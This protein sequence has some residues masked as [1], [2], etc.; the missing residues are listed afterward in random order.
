MKK[1]LI[2]TE[3]Q[4]DTII[5]KDIDLENNSLDLIDDDCTI[6]L[7][8]NN[9]GFKFDLVYINGFS[10]DS[11]ECKRIHSEI[12]SNDCSVT[13]HNRIT[14]EKF[15]LAKQDIHLTKTNKLYIWKNIFNKKVFPYFPNIVK[16]ESFI[17][18]ANIKTALEI[19]FKNN[20]VPSG[21]TYVA[22]VVGVAPIPLDKRGWSIMN[23]F[24]T[25]ASVHD[26]IKLFLARDVKNNTFIYDED[27]IEG[28]VIKWLVELFKDVKSDDMKQLLDIQLTSIVD[29]FKQ[30]K[31]DAEKIRNKYHPGSEI[32][33][34]GFGTI[35]DIIDSID[36]TIDDVTYQIKPLSRYKL[37]D[38]V[39]SMDIG[40]SN[41]VDY[42]NKKKLKRIAFIKGKEIF[43]FNNNIIGIEGKTYKFSADDLI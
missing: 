33:Y 27:D 4:L 42:T 32:Y 41:M 18:S 8:Y 13:L 39:Y 35:R 14:D 7:E 1:K 30:E 10:D 17:K 31:L 25:K 19:A 6:E 3:S 37:E 29:N 11:N 34:S 24:N 15:V 21:D 22:G 26:R 38:K 12:K 16:F 40:Y 5:N 2:I 36:V 20:W 28:S 43:V 9:F 23:F